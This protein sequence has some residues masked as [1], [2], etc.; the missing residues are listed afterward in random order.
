VSTHR[1]RLRG[2]WECCAPGVPAAAKERLN[3]PVRWSL[4]DSQRL[5]LTRHFGRPPFDP[6]HQKLMLELDQVGGMESL[7][8]NG[9]RLADVSPEKTHY[10][11]AL[12]GAR[13]RNTLVLEIATPAAG[14][15][16]RGVGPEWGLIVVVIRPIDDE[17]ASGIAQG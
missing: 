15:D 17:A 12:D 13:E 4:E 6:A 7:S 10:A 11:I 2:G 8:L 5:R 1:I 14:P 16:E 9:Q 3:L